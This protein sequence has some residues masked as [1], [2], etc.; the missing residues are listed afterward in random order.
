MRNVDY[1]LWRKIPKLRSQYNSIQRVELLISSRIKKTP[2]TN[3]C[4]NLFLI[5][6]S[7]DFYFYRS[8]QCQNSNRFHN[9]C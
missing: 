8:Q 7:L 4:K 1:N 9:K 3:Q 6:C 2:N 5:N